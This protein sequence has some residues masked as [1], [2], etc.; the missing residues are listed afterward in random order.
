[1]LLK[2][3]FA[4]RKTR[5]GVGIRGKTARDGVRIENMKPVR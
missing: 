3:R 5:R 2:K 4:D 1:L